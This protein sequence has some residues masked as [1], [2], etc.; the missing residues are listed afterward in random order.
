MSFLDDIGKTVNKITQGTTDII[1]GH[2][3]L[4]KKRQE[5]EDLQNQRQSL[6]SKYKTNQSEV[7]A[8]IN[9]LNQTA[10]T[11]NSLLQKASDYVQGIG[12]AYRSILSSQSN[13]VAA[14]NDIQIK[15][16]MPNTDQQSQGDE[17]SGEMAFVSGHYFDALGFEIASNVDE[18]LEISDQIDEITAQNNQITQTI[19]NVENLKVNLMIFKEY[20]FTLSTQAIRIYQESANF[21][22]DGILPLTAATPEELNSVTEQLGV[23]RDKLETLNGNTFVIYRFLIN[24]IENNRVKGHGTDE[25]LNYLAGVLYDIPSVKEAFDSSTDVKS[26][27]QKFLQQ[28]LTV[29]PLLLQLPPVPDAIK[30]LINLSPSEKTELDLYSAEYDP[31][32]DLDLSNLPS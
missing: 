4:I 28:E 6:I 23:F 5:L 15:A 21:G 10:N 32:D 19:Q 17:F 20:L 30:S 13:N 9:P 12:L 29:D 14:V 26:L 18:S 3:E 27:I 25:Q 11:A 16:L 22:F 31:P 1:S 7:Q 8:W 2:P 24:L